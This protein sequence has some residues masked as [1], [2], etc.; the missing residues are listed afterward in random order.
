[1]LKRWV[2]CA[3]IYGSG[4]VLCNYLTKREHDAERTSRV[5]IW[6]AT[7]D[8]VF[9][10]G[11]HHLVER[12]LP[13]PVLRVACEQLCYSPL[14]NAAYLTNVKQGFSWSI[15]DWVRLYS[16]DCLFWPGVSYMGYRLV[17]L[18]VRFLYI[19]TASLAWNVWRSANT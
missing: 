6:G 5:V 17:P 3:S 1:M 9:L 4:E 12:R 7:V 13:N 16:R 15:D 8:S 2:A 11:F 10:R 18:R 14:S 19:S